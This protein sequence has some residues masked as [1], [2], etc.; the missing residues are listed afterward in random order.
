MVVAGWPYPL[1]K[2]RGFFYKTDKSIGIY[3]RRGGLKDHTTSA[4]AFVRVYR[5]IG[6][7]EIESLF[8]G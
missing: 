6:G 5:R 2:L 7:L 4:M 1:A 8:N 3:H